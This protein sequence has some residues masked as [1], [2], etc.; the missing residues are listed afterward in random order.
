MVAVS[1]EALRLAAAARDHFTTTL[2]LGLA[3]SV[4]PVDQGLYEST[5]AVAVAGG[6][7][8]HETFPLRA[9]FGEI[10]RRAALHAADVLRRAVIADPR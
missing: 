9:A 6:L 10:Q 2:G 8:A 3:S 1:A 7:T 4:T 5:V